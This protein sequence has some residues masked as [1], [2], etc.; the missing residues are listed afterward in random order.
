MDPPFEEKEIGRHDNKIVLI[1][2][3]G[4]MAEVLASGRDTIKAYMKSLEKY[5][6][7]GGFIPFC[8]RRC[9]PNV[10]PE[11]YLYYLELK[12]KTFGMQGQRRAGGRFR[13]IFLHRL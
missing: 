11:D 2:A 13:R 10:K 7:R 3:D 9:P 6:A 1:N 8:D 12:E 4:V 5:V